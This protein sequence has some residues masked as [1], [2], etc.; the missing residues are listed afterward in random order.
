MELYLD[1]HSWPF[2]TPFT[3]CI[4]VT[5]VKQTFSCVTHKWGAHFHNVW[6]MSMCSVFTRVQCVESW[7]QNQLFNHKVVRAPL[8]LSLTC[9]H[10]R[11]HTRA[12]AQQGYSH[13]AT[14]LW[15]V[16]GIEGSISEGSCRCRA[17]WRGCARTPPA[18]GRWNESG[19]LSHAPGG[20]V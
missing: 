16:A 10:A 18:C 7:P 2:K 13:A 17:R 8:S 20:P 14:A 11:A 1:E 15:W 19:S 4:V 3:C 6:V 9:T 12:H 5:C